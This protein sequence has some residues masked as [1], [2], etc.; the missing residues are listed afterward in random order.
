MTHARSTKHEFFYSPTVANLF[1]AYINN[2]INGLEMKA[3]YFLP[4]FKFDMINSMCEKNRI[5]DKLFNIC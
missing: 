5:T 2:L 1:S 4:F 3:T